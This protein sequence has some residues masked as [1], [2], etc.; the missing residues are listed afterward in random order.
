[1]TWCQP[2]RLAGVSLLALSVPWLGCA[3]LEPTA[4]VAAAQRWNLA[5]A[6]VKAR[7]ASDQFA[8]GDIRGAANELAEACRLAPDN[9]DFVPLRARVLLAEGD[10]PRAAEL[11]E[12][13]HLEGKQQAEI[14]YLQGVVRQQQQNWDNALCSYLRAVELDDEEV[15]YVVAVAQARLQLGQ[16]RA[17]LDFLTRHASRFGWTN[18]YQAVLAESYEQV[19]DWPAAAAAWHQA[20]DA[21]GAGADLRERLATAL[22]RANRQAEAIP[23]FLPLLAKSAPG[24]SGPLRLMLAECYLAEGNIAAA[25]EQVETVLQRAPGDASAQRLLIRVMAA[26]GEYAA[27]LRVARRALATSGND[28]SLLESVTALAWRVGDKDLAS[29]T[30]ARLL[31][32][33][34]QNPVAQR[35]LQQSGNQ[36]SSG[37]AN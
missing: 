19:G 12:K 7:L 22:F 32:A 1:M 16:A 29:A 28:T 37:Q 25:R 9:P 17:A 15:A 3:N 13:T 6:Q 30:A 33:D 5:R 10:I 36:V 21:A 8:V 4:K 2:G 26:S 18:A 24:S 11:L 35:V 23:I 20:L 34:A 27:A 31:G 14:E